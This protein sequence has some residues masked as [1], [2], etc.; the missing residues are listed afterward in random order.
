VA[1]FT[2]T[3]RRAERRDIFELNIGISDLDV[4]GRIIL[5]CLLEQW[6]GMAWTEFV[7]F[8]IAISGVPL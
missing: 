1:Y 8:R 2:K 7:W 4:G 6:D 5:K 3:R